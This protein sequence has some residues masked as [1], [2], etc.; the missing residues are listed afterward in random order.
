MYPQLGERY[1]GQFVAVH[2]GQIVD[3]DVDFEA[4]FLRI[5]ERFEDTPVLIRLVSTT[6]TLELRASSPRLEWSK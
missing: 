6:P 1:L 5:Q 2:N 3:A 4:L